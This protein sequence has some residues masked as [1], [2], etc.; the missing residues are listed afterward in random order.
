VAGREAVLVCL[1][2]VVTLHH[3]ITARPIIY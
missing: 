2:V 3:C 1:A